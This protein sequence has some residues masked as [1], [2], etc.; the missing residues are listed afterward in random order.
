MNI[1][2][3]A[4]LERTPDTS[5]PIALMPPHLRGG[6]NARRL[7]HLKSEMRYVIEQRLTESQRKCIVMHY[8]HNMRRKDIADALGISPPQVTKNIQNAENLIREHLEHFDLC[9]NR[10]ERELLD[11]DNTEMFGGTQC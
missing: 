1:V 2:C 8:W 6:N 10:L 5:T 4:S 11:A 3:L 7:M 9:Y